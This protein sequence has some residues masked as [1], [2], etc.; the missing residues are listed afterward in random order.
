VPT[1]V[2]PPSAYVP[3]RNLRPPRAAVSP[4]LTAVDERSWTVDTE[5]LWGVDLYNH[6]YF[7]EAHE[8]WEGL[9]RMPQRAARQRAF[10]QALI[11]LA[12]ACLKRALGDAAACDRLATRGL[13]RL[14]S[15][16][17]D[18]HGRYMG[19]AVVSFSA[20]F[21]DYLAQGSVEVQQPPALE[22]FREG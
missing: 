19:L 8:A 15:I 12:A 17:T 4:A 5:Y 7:W 3:G 21:R 20:R 14:E 10:L 2:F 13:A 22:L 16:A 9:W 18:D 11:Q 6:G 1:G